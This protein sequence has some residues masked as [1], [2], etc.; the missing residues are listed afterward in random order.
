MR[1]ALRTLRATAARKSL[2]HALTLTFSLSLGLTLALTR[3]RVHLAHEHNEIVL[4][5]PQL[6]L[7]MPLALGAATP[8]V[9]CSLALLTIMEALVV[10]QWWQPETF[11]D[12][13]RLAHVVEHHSVNL[14]LGGALLLLPLQGSGS[15]TL[16]ELLKK[17]D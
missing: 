6:L 7:S 2:T 13:M 5:G 10:W 16:D 4:R 11:A 14:A 15:L 12:P 1:K 8:L 9:A 17:R 3:Y